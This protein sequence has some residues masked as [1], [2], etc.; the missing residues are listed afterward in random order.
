VLVMKRAG[1]LIWALLL[2]PGIAHG[3]VDCPDCIL[4]LWDDAAMTQNFG[5]IAPFTL[6]N[7]YL[8]IEFGSGETG[9]TVVEFSVSG[10]DPTVLWL[11]SMECLTA[12]APA[13]MFGSLP[14]PADTTQ[15]GGMAIGWS[16]CVAGS[17]ALFRIPMVWMNPIPPSDLVLQ[18][19][20]RY[21]PSN[22]QYGLLGPVFTQCH[23]PDY[24]AVLARGNRYVLNPSSPVV[25]VEGATWSRTKALYR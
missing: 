24:P 18:V 11:Q 15:A 22:P 25:Q 8:G 14:A 1:W 10:I 17:Q 9:L 2:A 23:V 6:K 7:V 21:P 20:H 4:G 3:F 5:T 13:A 12:E 19:R 16:H